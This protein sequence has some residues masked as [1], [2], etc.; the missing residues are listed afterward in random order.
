MVVVLFDPLT[1]EATAGKIRERRCPSIYTDQPLHKKA[2][3]P[4]SSA[5]DYPA[6]RL[7]YNSCRQ[8]PYRQHGQIKESCQQA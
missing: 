2:G 7:H 5:Q 4:Q 6:E 3:R 1:G 8:Q